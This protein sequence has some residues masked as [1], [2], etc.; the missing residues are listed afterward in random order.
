MCLGGFE[1]S[2][3]KQDVTSG[4]ATFIHVDTCRHVYAHTYAHTR[5]CMYTYVRAC[6]HLCVCVCVYCIK[7]RI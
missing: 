4:R 3:C 2:A 5:V 7:I 6:A 1:V